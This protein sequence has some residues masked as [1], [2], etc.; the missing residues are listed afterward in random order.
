MASVKQLQAV[1]RD[2]AGKGAA[3]AVR[4]QG[5]VPAVIY[6]AGEAARP[7]ALDANQAKQLI[8]A[9]HFLTTVFEIEVD[10][11][12]TRAIPRDY[13]LDPVKDF[14][15]HVDFLRLAEGQK[16]RVEVPVHFINQE[17]S[18]GLKRGGTLNIVRHTIELLVP[19]DAIPEF[20]EADLTGFNIG[21]SLHI[22]AIKLPEG[23]R[24]TV[25]ERD[26]TVATIVAPSGL[27]EEAAAAAAAAATAPAEPAPGA[28]PAAPAAA[29]A[30][31]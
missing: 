20:I 30:K 3:R 31:S 12:K 24:P 4:R 10:G 11:T 2:R 1:A 13:Q 23:A 27:K 5:R 28:A 25:A 8:F 26:F 29:P 22:S 9:G 21:D 14:P 18:P 7:I 19:A 6:G 15:I 17:A 16:I